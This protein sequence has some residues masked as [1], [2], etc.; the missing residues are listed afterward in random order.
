MVGG[1]ERLVFDYDLQLA[2]G[3]AAFNVW[4][5]PSFLNRPHRVGPRLVSG[6]ESGRVEYTSNGPG[7]YQIFMYAHSIQGSVSVDWRTE[8]G[9]LQAHA[10][11]R[12]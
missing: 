5:W 9:A 6:S 8:G 2:E 12:D 4:K 1:N 7:F 3:T 10:D 11:R